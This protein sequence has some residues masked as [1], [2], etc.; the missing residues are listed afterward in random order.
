M[1]N[2]RLLYLGFFLMIVLVYL[3]VFYNLIYSDIHSSDLKTHIR[4]AQKLLSYS[5]EH[6]LYFIPHPLFHILLIAFHFIFGSWELSAILL[7]ITIIA[8]TYNLQI[9]FISKVLKTGFF[10][11]GSIG[12][13]FILLI[14]S[15]IFIPPLNNWLSPHYFSVMFSGSGTPNI[16]H[17]PTY[18]LVRVFVLPLFYF[19]IKLLGDTFKLN[20]REIIVFTLLL[21]LSILAK[22][23]FALSFIPAYVILFALK[24]FKEYKNFANII[25]NLFLLLSIP[26]IILFL[27][28]FAAYMAG[29]RESTVHICNFCVWLNWSKIPALSIL[30]GIGFPLFMFSLNIR[31]NIKLF[32]Y[33]LAWLNFF[34]SLF[35]A[36]FFYEDG[37]R[38]L[39]GNFFWGYDLSLYLLFFVSITDFIEILRAKEFRIIHFKIICASLILLLHIAGGLYHFSFYMH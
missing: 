15:S 37:Y 25:K 19:G 27:Q 23:N 22:P 7:L 30:L 2:S 39:A 10:N 33:Q 16:L 9:F 5:L 18:Y 6:K 34:M 17:N 26:V 29:P 14:I 31:K 13:S 32:N 3:M 12:F 38:L 35:F 20:K 21:S 24:S 11:N 28:F 36:G 1:K 4:F 8:L